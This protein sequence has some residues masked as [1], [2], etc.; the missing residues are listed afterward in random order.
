M[1]RSMLRP[2]GMLLA[3]HVGKAQRLKPVLRL[4][5]KI[6]ELDTGACLSVAILDDDGS[7]K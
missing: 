2:T 6:F 1:G 4:A 5:E 3:K 7:L